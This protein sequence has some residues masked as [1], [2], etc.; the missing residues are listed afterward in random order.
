MQQS[1]MTNLT[2]VTSPRSLL[3]RSPKETRYGTVWIFESSPVL[4]RLSA[5][6]RVHSQRT[7]THA[8]AAGF[9]ARRP[10]TA[11]RRR[12]I[13]ALLCGLYPISTPFT[14]ARNRRRRRRAGTAHL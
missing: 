10:A 6:A 5:G 2:R 3:K 9:D 1:R 14:H 12:P 11:T 8:N 4:V 7:V 13:Q